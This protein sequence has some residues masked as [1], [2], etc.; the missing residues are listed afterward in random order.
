MKNNTQLYCFDKFQNIASSPYDFNEKSPID[1]F[2]FTTP[3]YETF[4]K[5]VSKYL[6][7]EKKCY[8]IKYDVNNFV[9]I[10]KY[11]KVIPDI[12][13]IDAIKN[14]EKLYKMIN[15]LFLNYKNIIIVGDDYI[16]NSVIHF[17]VKTIIDFV[18]FKARKFY[19]IY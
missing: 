14:S 1:N 19:P 2:Y 15:N 17:V 3:R 9:K 13:F 18:H 6:S 16:F 10:M 12:V 11:R 7:N 4:C 8:T 5:N